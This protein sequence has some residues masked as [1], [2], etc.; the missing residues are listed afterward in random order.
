MMKKIWIQLRLILAEKLLS[1][2]I[3]AAP[4][5]TEEK[6]YIASMVLLYIKKYTDFYK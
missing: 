4:D 5:E 3:T 2:A 1:M 6:E